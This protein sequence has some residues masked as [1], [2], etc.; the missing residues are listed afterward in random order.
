M[1]LTT[2]ATAYAPP[3]FW[4]VMMIVQFGRMI[5]LAGNEPGGHTLLHSSIPFEAFAHRQRIVSPSASATGISM[6]T[7]L[8]KGRLI[9]DIIVA[10]GALL[11][12]PLSDLGLTLIRVEMAQFPPV[13]VVNARQKPAINEAE[14]SSPDCRKTVSDRCP[15]ILIPGTDTS[16]Q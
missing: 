12:K 1:K 2:T 16:V 8:L 9:G 14:K 7:V 15:T 5:V 4:P 3:I 6:E 11:Y 10:T 13:P